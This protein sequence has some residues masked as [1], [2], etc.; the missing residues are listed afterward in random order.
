MGKTR[1]YRTNIKN[2]KIMNQNDQTKALH[3]GHETKNTEGTRAVP[4]YQTT[5][6]VFQ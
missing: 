6:Y 3:V 5:S 1:L 2:T 4:I